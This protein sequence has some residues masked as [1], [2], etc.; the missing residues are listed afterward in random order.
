M[1]HASS[2][3]APAANNPEAWVGEEGHSPWHAIDQA[4][5]DHYATLTGDGLGEWVHLDSERAARELPYGGTIV[6]GF[7]QVAHLTM[8]FGEALTSLGNVDPNHALNYGFDR[9]R[10]V[11][12]LPVGAKF[13]AKF[14][15]KDVR[16]H[17]SGGYVVKQDAALEKEDGALTLAAEWLFHISDRAIN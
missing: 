11:S 10:F 16:P 8:L 4:T 15:V 6:P 17:P 2:E 9:L 13:R 14:R 12:P 7:L 5:V 1:V 3:T